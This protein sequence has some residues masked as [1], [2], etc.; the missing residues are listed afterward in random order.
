MPGLQC[1]ATVGARW[2]T[3]HA[4]KAHLVIN[5]LLRQISGNALCFNDP[6]Y[7]LA[8]RRIAKLHYRSQGNWMARIYQGAALD[9]RF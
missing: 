1:G 6:I 4:A 2:L 7:V 8:G 9:T 3:L 5:E